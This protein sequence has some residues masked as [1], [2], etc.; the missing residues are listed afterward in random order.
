ME[1][2]LELSLS[3]SIN[4]YPPPIQKAMSSPPPSIFNKAQHIKYWLRCL[5]THLPTQYSSNDSQRTTLAFFTLSA[6]DL[7]G[8]LHD[9]T[10]ASERAEYTDWIYRCQHPDGGF[11]GF[12][13][14]DVGRVRGD[15]NP[16]SWDPANLAATFFALAALTV[17]GDG[18]ERVKKREC[19]VWLE[20]LQLNDGS[21][22]EAV[23]E[24]GK[25]EGGGDIRYCYLAAAVRWIL[26]VYEITVE[27]KDGSKDIDVSALV[28]FIT[29]SQV[30][31]DTLIGKFFADGIQSYEG[32][33]GQA[34]FHEAHGT[35]F[36]AFATG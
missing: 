13:G 27:E 21:F 16:G 7:L 18:L 28:G 25:I 2:Y 30:S 12:T 29:S 3:S 15:K 11:R 23:G 4:I 36:V 9:R 1:R 5:K 32:G 10:S 14:A 31:V 35:H 33:I 26:R 24:G 34:P 8:V 6:L 19:L 20:M 22:G 17:M